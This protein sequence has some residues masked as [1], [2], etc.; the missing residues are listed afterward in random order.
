MITLEFEGGRVV[1]RG[2]PIP[3]GR[4]EKASGAYVA[5]AHLYRDIVKQL[6]AQGADFRD[7]VDKSLPCPELSS[8]IQLRG[9][10]RRARGGRSTHGLRP[11]TEAS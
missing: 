4:F 1:A 5:P 6:E 10:Q 7:E 11:T 3:H 2:G 8:S 9:Y